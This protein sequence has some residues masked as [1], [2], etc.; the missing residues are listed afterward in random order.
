MA[1][2][3]VEIIAEPH[4]FGA[5]S[6]TSEQ[7]QQ[8]KVVQTRADAVF[9]EYGRVSPEPNTGETP[10]AYRKR[11]AETLA[12]ETKLHRRGLDMSRVPDVASFERKEAAIYADARAQARHPLDLKVGEF[13]E[14]RKTQ[15]GR[16]YSEFVTGAN[17]DGT[18]RGAFKALYA[19]H[20]AVPQGNAIGPGLGSDDKTVVSIPNNIPGR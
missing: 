1:Y 18:T 11:L 2:E 10:F 5:N 3:I 8:I 15:G 7:R 17:A 14:V 12:R 4:R 9:R 13:R 16:A 19:A 6:Y 20:I